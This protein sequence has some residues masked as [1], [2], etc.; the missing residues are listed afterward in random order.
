MPGDSYVPVFAMFCVFIRDYNI[1]PKKDL[2]KSLQV[3]HFSPRGLINFTCYWPWQSK[4][5]CG[6]C[7]ALD[8][9]GPMSLS[10]CLVAFPW[11]TCGGCLNWAF[12][13]SFK[14]GVLAVADTKTPAMPQS[15]YQ[16]MRA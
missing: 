14:R 7:C 12:L 5:Y 11:H 6:P 8:A 1:L 15:L 16:G 13:L 2:H 9:G 10:A 4:N 3:G